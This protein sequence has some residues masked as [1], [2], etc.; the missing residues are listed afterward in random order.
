MTT[1]SQGIAFH[2]IAAIFPLL[3][4]AELQEL[5][6]DIKTHGLN[7]PIWLYEG[8]ILDGRNRAL[9][10]DLVGVKP[11]Y[12]T[13][14]G[15]FQDAI[16][17]VWSENMRRR[18]LTSSQ[19][20]AAEVNR[21]EVEAGY[22]A[23]V[24]AMQEDGKKRQDMTRILPRNEQGQL[25]SAR[26]APRT[27]PASTPAP[28]QP[29]LTPQSLMQP[30]EDTP[31]EQLIVPLGKRD[32]EAKV[33]NATT[34]KR[35]EL[36]GTNRQY[37]ADAE[38]IKR[39]APEQFQA[40]ERGEKTIPQVKR[41]LKKA[42]VTATLAALPSSK[43]RVLYAD[44]PWKYGNSGSGLDNYGPAE[45][46]YPSMTISELCS[47]NVKELTEDNAVLFLWVTSPMWA[48]CWPVIKAWGFEYKAQFVWDKVKHN[49][50]HYN[51][52]RH[53]LLLVCTRGSCTPD[54]KTLIDSV[55][56]IERS[57]KHSEKPQEFRDIVEML[58][59][60]GKR[61]ELFARHTVAGWDV[62]GNE[63]VNAK[64]TTTGAGPQDPELN[65]AHSPSTARNCPSFPPD[66]CHVSHP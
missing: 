12:R 44:P 41:E 21:Q 38:K 8:K 34:T 24:Q 28:R 11:S 7:H 30:D 64:A 40:I 29:P 50:G 14:S 57:E 60:H 54:V 32:L 31:V 48:E 3:P 63:V 51:S 55:Q 58:Y 25:Q 33:A 22:K 10:C 36:A 16:N 49:F 47:L 56:V 27:T 42:E 15:R 59:P 43:Y 66:F 53:E 20:A 23:A 45:R 17:C 18:Q 13:F 46:H 52:V 1:Q 4:D 62:W 35:A 6:A 65:E 5:A 61:L 2:P 39:E 9:A 37:I 19:K 26:Q